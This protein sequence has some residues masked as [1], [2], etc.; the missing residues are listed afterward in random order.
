M[1]DL[2]PERTLLREEVKRL[3][4]P[5]GEAFR[6]PD[7]LER[8]FGIAV[9]AGGGAFLIILAQAVE[10]I[11]DVACGEIE[12]LGARRRHDMPG[13]SSQE[14]AAETQRLGEGRTQRG[15]GRFE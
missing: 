3:G 14:Q 6:L 5:P 4:H 15:K 11:A 7:A 1:L 8:L 12:A 10:Q 2:L 13:V 9:E